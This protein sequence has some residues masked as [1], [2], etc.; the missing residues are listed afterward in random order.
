MNI[1]LFPCVSICIQFKRI[2]RRIRKWSKE[3]EWKQKS[4]RPGLLKCN[5]QIKADRQYFRGPS[6][7][8]SRAIVFSRR[9]GRGG[10]PPMSLIFYVLVFQIYDRAGISLHIKN[11]WKI[12]QKFSKNYWLNQGLQLNWVIF[13]LNEILANR[14]LRKRVKIKK[15]NAV[16]QTA[17]FK[18]SVQSK[19]K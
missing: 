2:I 15:G 8:V 6:V 12:I 13:W 3:N 11:I 10:V 17:P 16:N 19:Y 7:L 5:D 14:Y 1:H 4:C 9:R 18:S